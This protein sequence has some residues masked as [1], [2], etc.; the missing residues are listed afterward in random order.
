LTNWIPASAKGIHREGKAV[1]S[2]PGHNKR[3]GMTDYLHQHRGAAKV[4]A[5]RSSSFRGNWTRQRRGWKSASGLRQPHRSAHG[6]ACG[7]IA[8]SSRWGWTTP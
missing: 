8:P 2:A 7:A 3:E 1:L 4:F 5:R 6:S